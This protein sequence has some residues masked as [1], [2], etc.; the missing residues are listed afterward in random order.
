MIQYQLQEQG[1]YY[2]GKSI[3]QQRM[4]FKRSISLL[5]VG[6]SLLSGLVLSSG[7]QK[8][9]DI[10][11]EI[12][13]TV[14]VYMA[15]G[16]GGASDLSSFLA[17]NAT[18]METG[19]KSLVGANGRLLCLYDL[20]GKNTQLL[21]FTKTGR[22]VLIEYGEVLNTAKIETFQRVLNEVKNLAPAKGYGLIL[23]SHGSGWLPPP[24]GAFRSSES[25]ILQ[26]SIMGTGTPLRPT[27]PDYG[28]TKAWG[29]HGSDWMT[30]E[31]MV[32]ALPDNGFDFVMFDACYMA[33]VELLYALRQKAP[34]FIVSPTEIMGEGFPYNQ[35][36]G[37]FFIANASL[38]TG[39]KEACRIYF[40]YYNSKLG[41][42]RAASIAL[43]HTPA[44]VPLATKMKSLQITLNED[45]ISTIQ[46]FNRQS[47]YPN[48]D[49]TDAYLKSQGEGGTNQWETELNNVVLF[50]RHTDYFWDLKLNQCSGL[51]TY[52][53]LS[54]SPITNAAYRETAWY[55]ATN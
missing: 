42:N 25:P 27:M 23:S 54:T 26:Q 16:D 36:V 31:D 50:V 18:Q 5:F 13:R 15:P 28:P 21:E 41:Q 44:L 55:K 46:K 20:T 22:K 49:F 29:Q 24:T 4:N 45:S 6:F 14:L 3:N 30:T 38:E 9:P 43:I 40:D 10:P 37:Q 11:E 19:M 51:S 7:C 39:L 53:P 8:D 1:L 35:M 32:A 33:S 12:E 47:S 17:Y 48:Y 2:I 34:Y 52:I